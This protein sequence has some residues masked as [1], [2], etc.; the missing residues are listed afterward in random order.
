MVFVYKDALQTSF[1]VLLLFP[2][3]SDKYIRG[4]TLLHIII[5]S[6]D[7][8]SCALHGGAAHGPACHICVLQGHML[9]VLRD[10]ILHVATDLHFVHV[11]LLLVA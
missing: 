10:H 8:L 1:L 7:L 11:T 3:D 6:F 4:Y 5:S 2:L 9:C